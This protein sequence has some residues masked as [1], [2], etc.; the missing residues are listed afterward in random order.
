MGILNP[1]SLSVALAVIPLSL[2]FEQIQ[3][4]ERRLTLPTLPGTW[5]FQGCVND[6]VNGVGRTLQAANTN[7]PGTTIESCISFCDSQ[8][9]F[10][11]GVEFADECYCGNVVAPGGT[12]ATLTDC[13]MACAGNANE[14]CGAGNRL[15][16]FWNGKTPPTPPQ[17]VPSVGKWVSLGCT[18]CVTFPQTLIY[19]DNVNG[20]GRSIANPT[21][22]VGQVSIETC[23]TACF[24]AGFGIAGAEFANQCFC[25]SAIGN[26]G[27]PAA[28]TDCNMVCQGNSSEFCGGPN[29]L[30]AYK[31]TGTDLP[32]ITGGG[33]GGGGGGNGG[34]TTIGVFPVLSGLPAGWSYNA[35]WV[36]NAHGR[37]FD[38]QLPGSQTNTIQ[39]CI[40][41][42]QA[43]NFTIAGS[44]F[45]DECYCGSTLVD[46]G[47]I[48]TDPTTC[49]MGCAGNTTQACGGPNRLS[50]YSSVKPVVALPVPSAMK[51]GLPGNWTY[52]GCLRETSV[53]KMFPEQIIWIGNNSALACMNQCHAFGYSASGV[54]FGQECYCGDVTDVTNN[55][56]VFGAET[57][58]TTPCPGDP[59]HLCGDGDRLSTYFWNGTLNNWKTPTNIGRYEFLIGGLVVPLI[60]TVGINNKV[61]FLEK[62]GTGIPNATGAYELDLTLTSNFKAAWREMHI[63]TDVFCSGSVIMPDKAGRQI[64]VAG[65]AEES[66]FGVR[67]YT[68]DG[69]AGVNGTNDWEENVDELFLQ[70]ARWYPTAAVLSNGSILV[71]GGEI[72]SNSAPQ[73]NLEVLPKPAGGDTVVPLDWLARTDP[74]NLYPFVIILPSTHIF[75][76]YFN[77]ARILNPTT[78][79]TI[80]QLPNIPGN[81]NNFLAGRTYPLE[82]SA[83]PLP[84]H[85]PYTDP[86]VILICGGSTNGAGD[87]IDNC[88]SI[89][90]EGPNPTWTLER[91]SP[92]NLPIFKPSKR[93]MP[94]MVSLPDGT[95]MILNGATQ[96]YAGF[97]LA[98]NPNLNAL[99]YD[100]TSPIGS[101]I[102]ILNNTIVAR[103]YHSEAVLLP[104]GRVLV[105]GSDPQTDNPDGTVKYPEEFRIEVY[106][107]PYLNQGFQQP[108][109]TLPKNDWAYGSTN[110]V[111]NV[112]LFQGPMANLKISL[113]AATSSTHG[114]AMG[115]R[116]I[117]PAF[118]CAGTTCTIT[119]PPNAG[120]SPPG[121]HQLF[122]LDGPTP[123]HSQWVRIGGDPSQL[124]NWPNLP[125]F[126]T[127]GL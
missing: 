86:L 2:A 23:T 25:A 64:N 127:P 110:T 89:A 15:D 104:D 52:A 33:G 95:V 38:F 79:D 3:N 93:V 70:R 61:T 48:A 99:L 42:C 121:W 68:P 43:N 6:N 47:V 24:N 123:S 59:V 21:N 29:R 69:S 84:Q 103:M 74:N 1:L 60:S 44:E 34:G 117:F 125:G 17:I 82:G 7:G 12:N 4:L 22:V 28:A 92:Y 5:R 73:P 115:A 111:I 112:K 55:K 11:A 77:E 32:P 91:M 62:G 49:N 10:F 126:T 96:G 58:C 105:S 18:T 120:V 81:V 30:N 50:V 56:G 53:G 101:R 88:V 97:G 76:G 124:G 45:S 26:G 8:S 87:A 14:P 107:P 35:C 108:T 54:E 20:A 51:T 114:N 57:E 119:A 102:S 9:F 13:N 100:P 72:G 113:V 98:N 46:G 106:I 16:L 75:V 65:W 36:D 31:Y 40:A 19:D 41:Q 109:F 67:I 90:P 116:T 37:I 27:G 83:V 85:A 94:N 80:V 118:T 71:M 63:K 122:I 39:S 66:N 78:F